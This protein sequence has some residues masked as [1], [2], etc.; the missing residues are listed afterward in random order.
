MSGG[1]WYPVMSVAEIIDAFSGWGYSITPEQ[2]ARPSPDFVL[3][4]YSTCLEQVTGITDEDLQKPLGGSLAIL[5]DTVS[6]DTDLRLLGLNIIHRIHIS[7]LCRITCFFFTCNA[8]FF[9]CSLELNTSNMIYL[10]RDLRKRQEYKTLAQK[11]CTFQT[12][13]VHARICPPSS[14]LSNSPNNAARLSCV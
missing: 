7:S 5:S 13:S 11:T 4:I 12:R 14:T 2:V 6:S 10:G 1:F 3:K 8:T 9:C